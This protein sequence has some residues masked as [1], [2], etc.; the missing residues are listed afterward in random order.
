MER[1]FAVVGLPGS[2]KSEVVKELE[3]AGYSKIYFGGLTLEVLKER[4]MEVSEANE[5]K[6]R[7][8]LRVENGMEAYAKL[9]LSKIIKLTTKGKD[10]VIDG[11]YSWEEYTF[12]KSKLASMRVIAV[13]APP[14][15]RY[16]RLS[17]R[18]TRPLSREKAE[19]RDVA[20]IEK[21]HQ[22]GPI[23]MADFTIINTSKLSNLKNKVK[24][25][26]N[27]KD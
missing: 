4:S 2:G 15:L 27:D 20:Q 26:I 13:Y 6:V 9:N 1:I 17:N 3:D 8:Q 14:S 21:L 16:D 22:A 12:L 11:L 18:P 7:E 19:S 25:I 5:R 23:A 10:V 24:E